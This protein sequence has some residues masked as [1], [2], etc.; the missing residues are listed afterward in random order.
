MHLENKMKKL[1][2]VFLLFTS[3]ASA[4]II[5]ERKIDI[6]F[7]NGVWNKQFSDDGCKSV[8]AAECSTKILDSLVPTVSVGMHMRPKK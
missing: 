8:D 7:G 5:D 3:I 4:T 6:Y 2:Y 1:I